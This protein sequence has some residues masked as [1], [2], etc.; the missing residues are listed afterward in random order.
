[1]GA[2]IKE[3]QLAKNNVGARIARE[4]DMGT[5]FTWVPRFAYSEDNKVLYLKA[6]SSI[7]GEY[8]TPEIFTYKASGVDKQDIALRGIWIEQKNTLGNVSTNMNSEENGY[9]LIANTKA[10]Y[11]LLDADFVNSINKDNETGIKNIEN[12]KIILKVI[13]EKLTDPIM[14]ELSAKGKKV[15]IKITKTDNGIKEVREEKGELAEKISDTEFKYTVEKG[16]LNRFIIIDNIGNQKLYE[17][18][19]MSPEIYVLTNTDDYVEFNGEKWYPSGTQVRIK[20]ADNMGD[21]TGYYK[22]TNGT[23]PSAKMW[24]NNGTTTYKDF[25]LTETMKYNAKIENSIGEIL[26]EDEVTIHIMPKDD[27]MMQTNYTGNIGAIYPVKV[28]GLV[29]G[30]IYGTE[31]YMYKTQIRSAAR[32]M[33]LI[34]NN[35]TKIMYVKIVPSPQGGY[36]GSRRNGVNSSSYTYYN[37]GYIFVTVDGDEIKIPTISSVTPKQENNKITVT[38]DAKSYNTDKTIAKYYY[39]IDGNINNLD[40]FTESDSNEYVFENVQA[41]EEHTINVYVKDSFGIIS[42]ITTISTKTANKIP[43]PTIEIVNEDTLEKVEYNGKMWYQPGTQIRI[44]YASDMT[45]LT[46][47]YKTIN[48]TTSEESS[49]YTTSGATYQ[50]TISE[51]TTYVA[52]LM[53]ST[54]AETEEVRFTINIMP[55][56]YGAIQPIYTNNIGAIYPAKIIGST[57]YAVYGTNTYNTTNSA[58]IT[59]AVHMGIVNLNETKDV[60]IKI[61][62]SP[63]GGYIGTTRNGVTSS[64]SEINNNGY[65]FVTKDG[66]EIQIPTIENAVLTGGENSITATI[67]ASTNMGTIEKY[68]YSIDDGAVEESNTNTYTFTNVKAFINHTIKVYVK[69]SSGIVSE[70][71]TL[72]G[73]TSNILPTPKVEIVKLAQNGEPL[74]YNGKEWYPYGTYVKVTYVESATNDEMKE[75]NLIGQYKEIN[76]ESGWESGWANDTYSNVPYAISSKTPYES[77]TYSFRLTDSTGAVSEEVSIHL[78]IMANSEDFMNQYDYRTNIGGIYPVRVTGCN[79]DKEIYGTDTYRIIYEEQK[80]TYNGTYYHYYTYMYKTAIHMGLLQDN[81][82]KDLFIKIVNSP[83][84]GYKGSTRN[85]ITSLDYNETFTGYIFV[86]EDGKEIKSP[87]L[88]SITASGGENTISVFADFNYT[89]AT[90]NKYYY[91]IDDGAYIESTSNTYTFENVTPYQFH[92]IKVYAKDSNGAISKISETTGK[93]SKEVPKP[94]IEIVDKDSIETVQ[95]N[96]KTWYPYGTDIK[97]TAKTEDNENISL[98]VKEDP[99]LIEF[100]GT[101]YNNRTSMVQTFREAEATKVSVKNIDDTGEE[102]EVEELEIYIMPKD[103]LTSTYAISSYVGQILPVVV[104]G[105]MGGNIYGSSVYHYSSYFGK[106]AMQMGILNSG[107]TKQLFIKVVENPEEYYKGIT[108][109]G[110]ISEDNLTKNIGYVFLDENGKEITLEQRIITTEMVRNFNSI[111]ATITAENASKY[112]YSI[113]NGEYVESDNNAYEFLNLS[114]EKNYTIKTY[115]KYNDGNVS[116]VTTDYV[117][118]RNDMPNAYVN[119]KYCFRRDSYTGSLTPDN[120]SNQGD[121]HNTVA[122]SYIDLDFTNY[123]T[124]DRIEIILNAEVSSQSGGDIGYATINKSKTAPAYNNSSGRFVYISGVVAAKDYKT[125]VQ[126]GFK[127]YLHLGYYKNGSTDSNLDVVKFNGL[128]YGI[129]A[130]TGDDITISIQS[131]TSTVTY[132]GE[133]WYPYGTKINIEY[134]SADTYS[135]YSNFYYG[136]ENNVSGSI[137]NWRA[138]TKYNSVLLNNR[139]VTTLTLNESGTYFAKIVNGVD[140]AIREKSMKINIMPNS[141]GLNSSYNNA[142]VVGK[143]FPVQVSYAT[144]GTCYG[145]NTYIYSSN[146]NVAATH[147]GLV[148]SNQKNITRYIKIVDC[149]V[150]GYIATTRNGVTSKASSPSGIGFIFVD[151]SGNEIKRDNTIGVVG[152]TLSGYD[153]ISNGQYNFKNSGT[154]IIPTNLGSNS[155]NYTNAEAYIEIDLSGNSEN[156]LYEVTLNAESVEAGNTYATITEEQKKPSSYSEGQIMYIYGT[157][158]ASDYMVLVPGGKKYYLHLRYYKNNK[159]TDNVKFNS[160]SVTKSSRTMSTLKN[161]T[162]TID[163]SVEPIEYKGELWY[164]FSTQVTV[165]YDDYYLKYYAYQYENQAKSIGTTGNKEFVWSSNESYTLWAGYTK[166]CNQGE[167]KM[168]VMPAHWSGLSGQQ[169]KNIGKIYPVQVTG[170]KGG[171]LYG[172]ARYRCNTPISSAATHM[173]LVNVNE[174]KLVY[175]KI[176]EFPEGG[177]KGSRM[178]NMESNDWTTAENGYVFVDED[179]NEILTPT[180]ES[181]AVLSEYKVYPNGNYYFEQI[182]DSIICSSPYNNT[183]AESYIELDLSDKSKEDMFSVVLNMEIIGYYYGTARITTSTDKITTNA[184]TSGNYIYV[185][186]ATEA[187]NYET[188]IP[189]GQKYYLHLG[190]YKYNNTNITGN[191]VKF[192]SLKVTQI[193]ADAKPKIEIDKNV[194][195][196]E[197]RGELWY[198]YNTKLT[199]NYGEEYFTNT[200]N[201][202]HWYK[203][204]SNIRD[205]KN[206]YNITGLGHYNWYLVEPMTFWAKYAEKSPESMLKVNVMPD[207]YGSGIDA[208]SNNSLGNI[209]PVQVT[210]IQWGNTYGN[211]VYLSYYK[212]GSYNNYGNIA[213]AATHMGL[214]NLNETKTVYVKFVQSPVGGYVSVKKNNITSTAKTDSTNNGFMFVTE[215]GRE[216]LEPIINSGVATID[217]ENTIVATV[218]AV[219][220]SEAKV[221]KYYYSIDNGEYVE[222]TN[223]THTFTD[224]DAY[225]THTVKIYVR[226]E[227]GAVSQTKEIVTSVVANNVLPTITIDPSAEPVEY[228]GELWYPYGTKLTINYASEMTNLTGYYTYIDE[229][230]DY[231]YGWSTTTNTSYETPLYYSVTYIAKTRDSSGKET[232]EVRKTINIMPSETSGGIYY[233][234]NA[235]LGNIYPVRVIGTTTESGYGTDTYTYNSSINLTATHMGLVNIGETKTVYIKIVPAPVGGYIGGTRYGITTGYD[236][237]TNNGYV[238]VDENGN[239]ITRPRINSAVTS[240]GDNEITVTVNAT[241]ANKY[242]YS[243]DDGEYIE[244]SKEYYTFKK[245]TT[246]G[247]HTIKIYVKDS[248]GYESTIYSVDGSR[249][250]PTPT[251]TFNQEP[252]MYNGEKWYPYNTQ[253]SI[254]YDENDSTS[255]IGYYRIVN[256]HTKEMIQPLTGAPRNPLTNTLYESMI[257]EAY[258]YDSTIGEG[259]HLRETINIMPYSNGLG[260]QPNYVNYGSGKVYPVQVTGTTSGNIWGTDT[261]DYRSNINKAATHAGLV[262]NEETKLVYIKIVPCPE[263]GYKSTTQNGITSTASTTVNM[264]YTFVQ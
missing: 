118:T 191:G 135:D 134:L 196:V 54:G 43:M 160:L 123:S 253:I 198:P 15:T 29:N 214:V 3:N 50:T 35:E 246:S 205:N 79:N 206:A 254:R 14:A 190:S 19:I 157:K 95:Y 161:P 17:I 262:K 109:N 179:G 228:N 7:A 192:N 36:I 94:T 263:G 85:G 106:A 171:T 248:S 13:D 74:E 233:Y 164:P 169:Y 11:A 111:K 260:A 234:E 257:Y 26:G 67:T 159:T 172:T 49:W 202:Y 250:V 150:D 66:K 84:G 2:G 158:E 39:N 83:E 186:S 93:V 220:Q 55:N 259:E 170:T 138:T 210:G 213:T 9:G 105:S 181:N 124:S 216:I 119:G 33:G 142:N 148:S 92:T 237:Y 98:Y 235:Y 108:I 80:T 32:H 45:N 185:T 163:P 88:N 8:T 225:K 245:V 184:N 261:Y 182:G 154:S 41:Y 241:N 104:T 86:T 57:G 90:Q 99:C 23:V 131:A 82:T 141:T 175:I 60:F 116:Y 72:I 156:E 24:S 177:Y 89:N 115:V 264:G 68:Y 199:L 149:P 28:T 4:E 203:Y 252:V 126:G 176:I 46:G 133:T 37:D 53:D 167:I 232:E 217:N 122:N 168:N 153:V 247:N 77:S 38:V 139:C 52:K 71:T 5:I 258:S 73:K 140:A 30:T 166:D 97:V 44:N 103:N 81:E 21:M 200:N 112:Y 152:A 189:G 249:N 16:G 76:T 120:G 188:I 48:E 240:S 107:E 40:N 110:V 59:S 101:W 113:E 63:A 221:Q 226:D 194:I 31:T 219:N 162:I 146:I 207:Q 12:N 65:V 121:K 61:V 244:N 180:A 129:K 117:K 209:Y 6:V 100:E 238:F 204:E 255:L 58:I 145:T 195:P 144:S 251:F 127:Y 173:G 136:Y 239:E 69:D 25:T 27:T 230:N 51:S 236:S 10:E 143:I 183:T 20:F 256:V 147:M 34:E 18:N 242:Y 125:T 223:N 197:Y 96:G 165:N 42:D 208:Y 102:S 1:M 70:V 243:I 151:A 64:Q 22:E 222:T 132:N 174:T 178:N 215:D 229:R 193:P 212:N 224:V 87:T 211:N 187:R 47:Y 56:I 201:G 128:S 62:P 114:P 78:N 91:S 75:M 130:S 227:F 231:R 137:S 218:N 155:A